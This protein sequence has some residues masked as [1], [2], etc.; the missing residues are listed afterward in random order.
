M[1]LFS[2]SVMEHDESTEPEIPPHKQHTLSGMG[3]GENT[4]KYD[5]FGNSPIHKGTF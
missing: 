2:D 5:G 1:Y 3:G 4:G